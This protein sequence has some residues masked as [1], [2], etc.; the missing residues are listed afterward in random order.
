MMY[1]SQLDH[2]DWTKKGGSGME[3]AKMKLI[4]TIAAV[5]NPSGG[6]GE[7]V[8]SGRWWMGG[9]PIVDRDCGGIELDD[10]YC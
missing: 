8:F 5:G 4:T 3:L 1:I 6:T 10:L 9:L 7:C 2:D